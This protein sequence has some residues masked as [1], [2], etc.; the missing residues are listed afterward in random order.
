MMVATMDKAIII[1]IF[2][3]L[4]VLSAFFSGSEIVY[5]Q[6]NKLRIKKMGDEGNK[7]AMKAWEI[8][9]PRCLD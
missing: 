9:L 4:I 2:V 1:I 3:L 5:S 7:K 8:S 6:V